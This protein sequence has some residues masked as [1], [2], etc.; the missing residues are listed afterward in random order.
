[1]GEV[2]YE[3]GTGHGRPG[4][5]TIA[6]WEAAT[7]IDIVASGATSGE[8]VILVGELIHA[9]AYDEDSLILAGATTDVDNY[10]I[11]R[12]ATSGKHSQEEQPEQDEQADDDVPSGGHGMSPCGGGAARLASP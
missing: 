8:G 3:I 6:A 7:D 12:S 2:V 9:S 10:R 11:L 4:Y 1:M 5:D